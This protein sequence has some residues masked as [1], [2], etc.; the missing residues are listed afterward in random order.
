MEDPIPGTSGSGN[1]KSTTLSLLLLKRHQR[2]GCWKKRAQSH[3]KENK[4]IITSAIQ[5]KF[6]RPVQYA[7]LKF[8]PVAG[9]PPYTMLSCRDG[10]DKDNS[11]DDTN[12]NVMAF[13]VVASQ[14]NSG[15]L[16]CLLRSHRYRCC[17]PSHHS[18]EWP[19]RLSSTLEIHVHEVHP[20]TLSQAA[21]LK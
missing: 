17:M 14:R 8:T 4:S 7:V 2:P 6:S 1:N 12:L 20:A 10:N 21:P 18:S 11:G 3:A 5:A 15:I 16:Q 19:I 9:H 13:Y